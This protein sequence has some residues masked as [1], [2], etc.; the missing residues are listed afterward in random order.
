[1]LDF[2]HQGRKRSLKNILELISHIGTG[3]N[4]EKTVS[5]NL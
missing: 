1:M 3:T 5:W 2:R 4:K